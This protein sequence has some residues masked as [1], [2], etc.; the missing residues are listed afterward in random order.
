M[1]LSLHPAWFWTKMPKKKREG[2]GFH[3][4]SEK[5]K[6]QNLYSEGSAAYAS[7]KNLTKASKLPVSKVQY[8]VDSKSS[9]TRFNQTTRKFR[10]MRAF[11]R[12]RNANWCMELAFVDNLS[13]NNNGVK[14]LL[15]Q[16]DMFDRTVDAKGKKTKDSK[17]TL[18]IFPK[19]LQKRIDQKQLGRPRYRICRAF[20]KVLCCWGSTWL[21][22]NEWNKGNLCK[23][24]NQVTQ[25]F[26][27]QIYGGICI[28]I[29]SQIVSVCQDFEFQKNSPDKQVPNKVKSSDFTSIL[30][31]QPIG[32]FTPP[33]FAIGDKVRISKIALPFRKC[34]KPQFTEEIFEIV[35]LASRKRPTYTIKDN[36]NLVIRGKFYEKEMIRVIWERIPSK[37]SSSQTHPSNCF[38]IRLWVLSRT[39][40]PNKST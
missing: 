23:E 7:V 25:K 33:K 15:V 39:S 1:L 19:W 21:F 38:R 37:K 3:S 17:E 16:Q 34:Y 12:F 8:F 36:E 24:N 27:I 11:A 40:F 18:K 30:Y 2:A 6:L 32:E 26:F 4:R 9:Y 31:G 29:Y 5:Q 13:K 10:R 20:R 22:H 14:Y 28:Q 35:A